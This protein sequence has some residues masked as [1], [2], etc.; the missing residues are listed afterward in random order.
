MEFLKRVLLELEAVH[1]TIKKFIL[2][3]ERSELNKGRNFW[4]AAIYI[5]LFFLKSS[6]EKNHPHALRGW[7]Q[8]EQT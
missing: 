2:E 3:M 1:A 8:S 4:S 5:E 7:P 6:I